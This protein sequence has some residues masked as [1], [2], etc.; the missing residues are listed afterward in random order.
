MAGIT[1]LPFRLVCKEHGAD[2]VYSEMISAAGLLHNKAKTLE[3]VNS[4][5]Q[6]RPLIVQL[7]GNKATDFVRAAQIIDNLPTKINE[8]DIPVPR[9]PEGIDI[10]FGCPVKKVVK[11]GAGCE[12]MK[13]SA[14]A[15]KI[16]KATANNT[17]LPISIKIRAG[18]GSIDAL[19]FLEQVADL[20]WKT[21]IIHGRTFKDGFSGPIDFELIKK[22][23]AA[24]PKKIVIA[25]GGIL[26]PQDAKEMLEK[27]G[28]DGIAIARGALG[29]PWIFSQI[30]T[31]LK[32]GK[33]N[34]PTL[35]EIKKT[36]LGHAQL[37]K[38][39]K[40]KNSACEFR[41]HLGWYFKGLPGVKEIRKQLQSV[42]RIDDIKEMLDQ[43]E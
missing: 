3:Y 40:G 31:F 20:N 11:Q 36:A 6:D 43:I 8:V 1:D 4:N 23:K 14:L 39:Y 13:N 22:I 9:R 26:T 12:L 34:E 29:S 21:V 28:A 37:M 16:I 30:K 15:R 38:I 32:T 7:F 18:V 41:K 5:W 24:F 19:N 25:N 35:E 2:L 17:S 27:T 33:Y 42:S 10:N